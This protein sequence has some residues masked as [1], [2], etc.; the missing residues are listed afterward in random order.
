MVILQRIYIHEIC[1]FFE[2]SMEDLVLAGA[3]S[4]SRRFSL[5]S[6]LILDK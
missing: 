1:I 5:A 4:P 3:L 2:D 6:I